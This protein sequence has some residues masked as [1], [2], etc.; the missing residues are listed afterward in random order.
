MPAAAQA[1]LAPILLSSNSA[2]MR[3]KSS[4][5]LYGTK[6]QFAA[7]WTN[8][9]FPREPTDGSMHAIIGFF[10]VS[11][12]G[13]SAIALALAAISDGLSGL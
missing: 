3:A 6:R 8:G 10:T 13:V 2:Q 12:V 9:I 7:F 5:R 11:F 4:L 1:C